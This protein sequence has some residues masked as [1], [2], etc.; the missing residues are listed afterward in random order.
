[1]G[2]I[3]PD[4]LLGIFKLKQAVFRTLEQKTSEFKISG[5]F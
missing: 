1:M 4:K 3:F 2:K 5:F